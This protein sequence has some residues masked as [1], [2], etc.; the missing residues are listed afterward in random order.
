MKNS[1]C[2]AVVLFTR[3]PHLEGASKKFLSNLKQNQ[4]I[5]SLLL[6]QAQHRCR[7]SGLDWF[8]ISSHQ[9]K[10]ATFSQ[11]LK[12]AFQEVFDNG[13]DS[14]IVIGSDTPSL[15]ASDILEAQ[16]LL[17]K[18]ELVIG[19]STDGGVYL[20]GLRYHQFLETDFDS[21]EWGTSNVLFQLMHYHYAEVLSC[22]TDVDDFN[23]LQKALTETEYSFQKAYQD[24]VSVF[25]PKLKVVIMAS[26]SQAPSILFRGPPAAH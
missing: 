8:Q 12:N 1:S 21:V 6:N 17:Q 23:S 15:Q 2:T 19:P 20:I 14:V 22:K 7:Q 25:V 16:R 11:R 26:L 3:T 24:I 13:Y 9:Q 4:R 18:T 5:S 10:G